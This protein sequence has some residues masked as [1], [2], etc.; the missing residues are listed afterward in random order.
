MPYLFEKI[1]RNCSKKEIDLYFTTEILI[2]DYIVY[3]VFEN[4]SC[5]NVQVF[6]VFAKNC[7]GSIWLT[8]HKNACGEQRVMLIYKFNKFVDSI[9][10]P[11]F[12]HG[13]R[14]C[15]SF[16]ESHRLTDSFSIRRFRFT[17]K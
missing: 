7:N 16:C 9:T 15:F 17:K 4:L 10:F 3:S 1:I 13:L 12:L 6:L 2:I 5:S 14:F 11:L 8:I